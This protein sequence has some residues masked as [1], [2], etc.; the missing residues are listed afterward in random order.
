MGLALLP[1]AVAGPASVLWLTFVCLIVHAF[2]AATQDVAIDALC[3]SALPPDERG[4]A[5]GWMQ[6]GM[7][8]GRSLFGGG[9][10]LLLSV[11]GP[12]G[13]IVALIAVIW[14]IA[15]VVARSDLREADPPSASG[16]RDLSLIVHVFGFLLRQRI[17]WYAL[18][19]GLL[20]GAV[21][22]GLGSVAGPF[23]VDAGFDTSAAGAFFA[24]PSVVAMAAGALAGGVVSD[25]I[26]ALRATRTF[27]LSLVTVVVVFSVA[28]A[29]GVTDKVATIVLLVIVYLGI[30]LFTAA[31]YAMF[32]NVS[33]PAYRATSFSAFMGSTNLCESWSAFAVGRIVP[34][35]GYGVAFGVM[36][37]LSL[38]SL[39]LLRRLRAE[40]SLSDSRF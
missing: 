8:L 38:A 27:F 4:R 39:P 7:L 31:S 36:A 18:G 1:L 22:E 21:F 6:A 25:R 34:S 20:A 15:L 28:V 2:L 5:N 11:L 3:I 17:V 40:V 19:F 30:G 13:G 9:T 26:G 33:V 23:L 32:M 37:V 29:A 12:S 24:F 35:A 10:L 14:G 16:R